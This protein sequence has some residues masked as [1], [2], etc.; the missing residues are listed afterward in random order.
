MAKMEK[1]GGFQIATDISIEIFGSKIEVESQTLE[2]TEKPAPPGIYSVPKDYA[3]RDLQYIKEKIRQTPGSGD[4][5]P[6][7]S[8]DFD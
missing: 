8:S 2:V 4:A 3:K 7:R 5:R 6:P 1:I